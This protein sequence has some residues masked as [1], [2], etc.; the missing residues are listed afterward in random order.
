MPLA[1]ALVLI[2]EL[3]CTVNLQRL[4]CERKQNSRMIHSMA[5]FVPGMIAEGT[6]D[7]KVCGRLL[8]LLEERDWNVRQVCSLQM[9]H[10]SCCLI[11]KELLF[12]VG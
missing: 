3:L 10:S 5:V 11:R 1:P 9:T 2:F 4:H 6:G 7:S 8:A 12:D